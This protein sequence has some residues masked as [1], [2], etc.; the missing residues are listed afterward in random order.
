MSSIVDVDINGCHK[1]LQWYKVQ[2]YGD[3]PSPR[4]LHTAN[5]VGDS[6]YI[7]GGYDGRNRINSLLKFDFNSSKWTDLNISHIKS[8]LPEPRDRHASAVYK[9]CIYIFGGHNGTEELNDIWWYNTNN[10]TWNTISEACSSSRGCPSPRHSHSCFVFE[11]YIYIFGGN[12]GRYLNDMWRFD[13]EEKVWDMINYNHPIP[14][15]TTNSIL[16]DDIFTSPGVTMLHQYVIPTIRW[17]TACAVKSD[18]MYLFGGHDGDMHLRD[19]YVFN[20]KDHY[21][22]EIPCTKDT[23]IAR[24]SHSMIECGDVLWLFGGSSR[25]HPRNDLYCFPLKDKVWKLVK[26]NTYSIANIS[27]KSISLLPSMSSSSSLCYTSENLTSNFTSEVYDNSTYIKPPK[28]RFCHTM[29]IHNFTLYIFGGYDGQDRLNDFIAI[30]LYNKL[31]IDIPVSTLNKDLKGLLNDKNTADIIF[32]LDD[33]SQINAH[34][35]I[36]TV[37]NHILRLLIT[38]CSKQDRIQQ[39]DQNSFLVVPLQEISKDI[40]LMVLEYLYTDQVELLMNLDAESTNASVHHSDSDYLTKVTQLFLAADKFGIVRLQR[41]CESYMIR[42]IDCNNAAI[43]LN[44]ADIHSSVTLK[45]AALNFILKNF[46]NVTK[47]KQFEAVAKSNVELILEIM[48]RR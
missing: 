16:N 28:A 38:N 40:L 11:K 27:N 3:K 22:E 13:T 20:L 9:D 6:M 25:G 1:I 35:A 44:I 17:R 46:D 15:V 36:I 32:Q 34:R 43:L 8:P 31:Y 19:F 26:P 45:E 37:R 33:G 30:D 29:A 2:S 12:D 14:D 41:M 48:Q 5:V 42:F 4:S 21:W 39:F 10:Y 47:T 24:D 7:F 23:P 18:Q